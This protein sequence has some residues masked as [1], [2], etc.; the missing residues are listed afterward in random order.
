MA[1]RINNNVQSLNSHR[2]LLVNNAKMAKTLEKLSSG[3]KI[4]RAA[5]S[6][7]SLVISEQM[8]AQIAG[9]NQA[10]D[11]SETAVSLVQTT[12]ANMAEI[13]NLLV[14]IRQL[15]IHASNE[16]VND[17]IML[18]A[19]QN[20]ID[21]AL[22]TIDRIASQAQFGTKR[23]LDGSRGAVGSTTGADLEFVS[24]SLETGDSREHGFDVKV[25]QLATKAETTGKTILTD[26]VV[27]AGEQLTIIEDGKL[28][29]YTSNED[30]T[31]ATFI[32]NM[33]N[34]INRNGLDITIGVN[35]TGNVTATHN[36]F[37]SDYKFQVSS[38]SDGILSDFG[39]DID[40]IAAGL[41][42]K[43][44][45]NG[46]S[47]TGKG[48]ILTGVKGAKCVDGL[49][50]RYS[51]NGDEGFVKAACEVADKFVEGEEQI[52]P[53]LVP[54]QDQIPT[55]GI[56][57]GRVFVAQNAMKFQV[58]ANKDQIVGISVSSSKPETL[59]RGVANSSG[60]DSLADIDVTTFQGAQDALL[61][62]DSAIDSITKSRGDIGAFQ[63]NTLESNLA[64]LRVQNENMINSESVIRDVDMA[65]EMAEFTKNQIMTQS[66]TA[67]LAQANQLPQN[68]LSLL[69]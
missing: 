36:R 11:N 7:A 10:I 1:Y 61:L 26:E 8:R 35:E 60:Y 55:D 43:G 2:N 54:T 5:D 23:L 4:N 41:D 63:K 44:T 27:K 48:Q 12:E 24:A 6:P 52:D 29:T 51:G 66:A 53:N 9:L 30:D 50:V 25:T 19:D 64:N 3:M 21:N 62:I 13:N 39:G 58:G 42:I 34:E 65:K 46:E 49:S 22:E 47:A 57:V 69:Q 17:E 37:G 14:S 45:I 67:M 59:A 56:S 33:Q 31:I 40:S 15:A 16:G 28:A 18:A 38:T 20:E 68:V 32:Q